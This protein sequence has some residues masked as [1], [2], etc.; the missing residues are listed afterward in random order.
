MKD[1][2]PARAAS[3]E[4]LAECL[5]QLHIRADKPSLR[6]LEDRTKFMKEVLP[7]T[8]LQR[9]RLGRT[10]L[11]DVLNGRKFPKKAFL[12]TFV[13]ALNVDLETDRRWEQAWDRLASQYIGRAAEAEA[14]PGQAA[15][16]AEQLRQQ[17]TAAEQRIH[18][19]ERAAATLDTR[20]QNILQQAGQAPSRA[21]SRKRQASATALGKPNAQA[22]A[23]QDP[24]AAA[25][26]PPEV[27][28]FP[29]RRGYY[30]YQA[31][32]EQIRKMDTD[33]AAGVLARLDVDVARSVLRPFESRDTQWFVEVM[34][35]L[36]EDRARA[37]LSGMSISP[38]P[39]RIWRTHRLRHFLKKRPA[40]EPQS[41][42]IHQ[43]HKVSADDT[44]GLEDIALGLS[45]LSITEAVATLTMLDPADA[46]AVLA[47]VDVHWANTLR[48][49]L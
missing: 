27:P 32:M 22:E 35:A 18:E 31:A 23:A 12:L 42:G 25:L 19:L 26:T 49:R 48:R 28:I 38:W 33:Q 8:R 2:D 46:E 41:P 43:P 11:H 20:L 24:F 45:K 36:P 34:E 7:G 37:I 15:E 9:V 6:Q 44:A 1:P 10:T 3:L 29:W 39:D 17:L 5:R 14:R 30:E 47:L 4:D 21:S 40:G 13:E 16:E